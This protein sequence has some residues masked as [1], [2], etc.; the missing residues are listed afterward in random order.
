MM[1]RSC[2]T[3][4]VALRGQME[5]LRDLPLPLDGLLLV[6]LMKVCSFSCCCN[7]LYANSC[8]VDQTLYIFLAAVSPVNRIQT[9]T[10]YSLVCHYRWSS[11]PAT[12]ATFS[13]QFSSL[14]PFC[15]FSVY[16]L[17]HHFLY[18][19]VA[20]FRV[21]SWHPTKRDRRVHTLLPWPV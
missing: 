19:L 7:N 17:L 6:S 18:L 4:T 16:L 13:S 21:S 1:F 14:C 10:T 8:S 3:A 5:G 15:S 2:S 20:V 11:V 12:A 9:S